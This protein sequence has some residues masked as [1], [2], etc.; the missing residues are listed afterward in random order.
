LSQYQWEMAETTEKARKGAWLPFLFLS[1][2]FFLAMHDPMAS[3]FVNL[4]AEAF[5]STAG[6]GSVARKLSFMMLALYGLLNLGAWR[7]QRFRR[8]GAVGLITLLLFGWSIVSFGWSQSPEASG[9]RLA[10]VLILSFVAGTV[11]LQFRLTDIIKW[12]AVTTLCFAVIGVAC[13]IAL[14]TFHPLSPEYRFSGTVSANEQGVSCAMAALAIYCL[15]QRTVHRLFWAGALVFAILCTFLTK[16]RTSLFSM[17]VA[18]AVFKMFLTSDWQKRVVIG[19]VCVA[20]AT[21]IFA[22]NLYGVV[23]FQSEIDLGRDA[24]ISDPESL[25]G[26]VPLWN[27][28]L[29]ESAGHRA[30]GYGYGGFWSAD[31]IDEVSKDQGW[32]V[33]AAHSAYLDILLALGPLGVGLYVTSLLLGIQRARVRYRQSEDRGMAFLAAVQVFCL[34]DGVADSG[35]VQVSA[36]LC[37]CW[38]LSLFYIGFVQSN[39]ERIVGELDP[40]A[41]LTIRP[42]GMFLPG[43]RLHCVHGHL[44]L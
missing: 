29:K 42:E 22:L 1:V 10:G 27:E 39:Q 9:T 24:R 3:T 31:R 21:G 4:P 13:E 44:P 30:L 19:S 41:S 11:S 20:L 5:S 2:C 33:S 28:L 40:D 35:P 14:G 38:I 16:S 18:L 7:S 17:I 12:I 32:S 36:F 43:S 23:Q 25:T 26:R 15:M 8:Q 37:F 6:S 34:I